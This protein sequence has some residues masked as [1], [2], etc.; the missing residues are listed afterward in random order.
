MYRLLSTLVYVYQPAEI[1]HHHHGP[2]LQDDEEVETKGDSR[3][4][5][6]TD[7]FIRSMV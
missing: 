5:G 2:H 3:I 6:W 7:R 1:D 4:S